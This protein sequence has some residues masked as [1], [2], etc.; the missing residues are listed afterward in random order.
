M[1]LFKKLKKGR[2]AI[3]AKDWNMLTRLVESIAKSL[4]IDS[5]RNSMGV[6]TRRHLAGSTLGGTA[7][8]VEIIGESIGGGHYT[9]TIQKLDA[10]DWD[11]ETPDQLEPADAEAVIVVNMH[12]IPVTG[13]VDFHLLS[14]T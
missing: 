3:T 14:V 4:G 6:H 5:I 11:T 1:G 13:E 8:I 2:D 10:T 12:E 9:A 7:I